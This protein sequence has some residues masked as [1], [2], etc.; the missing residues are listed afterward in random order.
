VNNRSD[1]QVG[2]YQRYDFCGL[3]DQSVGNLFVELDQVANIDVT[4]VLLEE[5][6]LAQLVAVDE[7]I[8]EPEVKDEGLELGAD[9]AVGVVVAA[10]RRGVQP[11]RKNRLLVHV[12]VFLIERTGIMLAGG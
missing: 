2:A 4:V 8:V 1:S 5:R 11:A 7:A 10:K 6:I 3:R 9:L 12:E